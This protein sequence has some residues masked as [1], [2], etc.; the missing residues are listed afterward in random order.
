MDNFLMFQS[1]VISLFKTRLLLLLLRWQ[2][3][4]IVSASD[5]NKVRSDLM[6]ILLHNLLSVTGCGHIT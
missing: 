2:A 6:M 5:Y 3:G 1:F 4:K